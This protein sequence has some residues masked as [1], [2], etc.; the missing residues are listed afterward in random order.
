MR[1]MQLIYASRPF[2]YDD[3]TLTSILMQ[4]RKNNARVGIT[5]ALAQI[6][7]TNTP[8]ASVHV[9][10]TNKA[11]V[12]EESFQFSADARDASGNVLTGRPITWSSN[13]EAVATVSATGLVTGLSPGGAIISA[14]AE[15]RTT[16]AS[17]TV[18]AIP[19]AS[20]QVQPG[21]LALTDGQT[22]ELQAQPLDGNGK[23]LVGRV[24]LWFTNNA[25]VA[26]VTATGVVTAQSPGNAIITATS[27]GKSATSTVTVSAPTPNAVVL[28][29]A[30]LLVQEG[31]TAQL[32]AQ[33][34]DNL[35]R[36]MPN[37]VV[38]Y[39]TSNAAIATVNAS[40]VVTAVAAGKVTITGSSSGKTGT[41]EVTVTPVPVAS[42][43]V[44]PA[45]PTIVVGRSVTLTAQALNA[46]GQPLSGRVIAWSSGAPTIATV[47]STGV[48][49]GVKVG[50]AVIFA[51]IDGVLG[52]TTVNVVPVPVTSVTVSPATSNIAI[53]A[54][55]QLSAMLYDASGTILTGRVIAWSS[56]QTAIATVSPTG[57]V[58][59]VSSGT[60]TITAMSEGRTGTATVNVASAGVRTVTVSPSTA[61][62][63]VLGTVTLTATVR[64][65]SGAI[66]TTPVTWSTSNAL[67]A[68]V[69]SS[70][71]VSGLLPGTVTIT[72]KSGSATGTATVTVK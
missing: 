51:S 54:T 17:V 45:Q 57:L 18:T 19:V 21:T 72:A 5:G 47:S 27:E 59:G 42:V 68:G 14:T 9:A 55:A 63:A 48:V 12:V 58:T 20:V 25:S 43:T 46:N 26:T 52:W 36:V 8:V 4:A 44:T 40:G 3:L 15:G 39:A 29:P 24:V 38:T 32:S 22:A 69:S 2:G 23:P 61:T 1:E 28:T 66:I 70:G 13:N 31:S 71:V 60:V 34:L 37:A 53:G 11:L 33:V 41:A 35:G 65:P 6:T 16:P 7:V 30:Q 49:S 67:I 50:S 62:I 56:S 64:D 10:P